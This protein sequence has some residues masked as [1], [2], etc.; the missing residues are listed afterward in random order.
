LEEK[1][2]K[3]WTGERRVASMAAKVQRQTLGG[4]K[5]EKAMPKPIQHAAR[6]G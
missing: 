6:G 3:A 2:E 4:A 5:G 1:V